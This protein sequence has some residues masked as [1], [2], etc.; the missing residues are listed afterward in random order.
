MII[1][2]RCAKSS[3]FIF[4]KIKR[5]YTSIDTIDVHLSKL[6]LCN[7]YASTYRYSEIERIH[8]GIHRYDVLQKR[9][10]DR[11][12]FLISGSQTNPFHE[13]IAPI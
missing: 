5:E 3:V 7:I 1:Y 2:N 9:S 11:V 13:Q 10:Y 6:S 4:C 8:I 12:C